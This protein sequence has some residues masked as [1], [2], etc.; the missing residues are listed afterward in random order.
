MVKRW[1]SQTDN[2]FLRR[3]NTLRA[4]KRLRVKSNCVEHSEDKKQFTLS[5][6]DR[7]EALFL[8]RLG[9][10]LRKPLRT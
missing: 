6:Q 10:F 9:A 1:W 4:G 8:V 2:G 7:S 5:R 3:Y